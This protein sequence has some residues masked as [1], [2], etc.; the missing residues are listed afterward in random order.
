MPDQTFL[1]ASVAIT[2]ILVIAPLLMPRQDR[3]RRRRSA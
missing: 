2:L 1:Y 3:G